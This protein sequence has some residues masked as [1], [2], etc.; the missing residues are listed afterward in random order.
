M[1]FF[2]EISFA[3]ALVSLLFL[4]YTLAFYKIESTGKKCIAA[5]MLISF[6][7]FSYDYLFALSQ[8][9]ILSCLFL[10]YFPFIYSLYPIAYRYLV[11]IS[12][13]KNDRLIISV[14]NLLPFVMFFV[15]LVFYF[16]LPGNQQNLLIYPDF[17]GSG[18][19]FTFLSLFQIFLF[20]VYYFQ[21]AVFILIFIRLYKTHKKR[22]SELLRS[23]KPFLPDW[24]F[25]LV[26][27]NLIYE[28][29][30]ALAFILF[31]LQYYNHLFSQLANLLL[32]IVVIVVSLKHDSLLLEL[33]LNSSP[34]INSFLN[35]IQDVITPEETHEIISVLLKLMNEEKI[36]R[37]P[38]LKL[39]LLAKKIA[40]PVN[41][42]SRVINTNYLMNFSQFV[43]KYRIEEA[44]E[45]LNNPSVRIEEI[46]LKVGYY[47]RSTFNRAF[48]IHTGQTPPD[49]FKSHH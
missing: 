30:Y 29:I 38:N 21:F 28:V 20:A 11:F 36:Y 2:T 44:I 47:T 15:I 42:L 24:I 18:E 10:L 4:A 7:L 5:L 40:L 31:N 32:L 16:S 45:L 3:G 19:S 22:K 37:N 33:R 39:E 9:K 46:Y 6:Y 48:K 14:F 12:G 35:K 34:N 49:Y 27:A 26:S 13:D 17:P 1:N 41:K 23:G 8:F 43:N 25:L